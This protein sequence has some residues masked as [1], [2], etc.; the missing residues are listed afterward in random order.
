MH[1]FEV[2]KETDPQQ[3][4]MSIMMPSQLPQRHQQQRQPSP[5]AVIPPSPALPP[6]SSNPQFQLNSEKF[7]RNH[8]GEDNGQFAESDNGFKFSPSLGVAESVHSVPSSILSKKRK[9]TKPFQ[10]VEPEQPPSRAPL[11]KEISPEE[12]ERR[13]ALVRESKHLFFSRFKDDLLKRELSMAEVNTSATTRKKKPLSGAKTAKNEIASLRNLQTQTELETNALRQHGDALRD[14]VQ[15]SL[16]IPSSGNSPP[17]PRHPRRGRPSSGPPVPP[18]DATL[19]RES[20]PPASSSNRRPKTS[21]SSSGAVR[22]QHHQQ[23]QQQQALFSQQQQQA[24]VRDIYAGVD[25]LGIGVDVENVASPEGGNSIVVAAIT[26]QSVAEEVGFLVGDI[27]TAL[28]QRPI[29]S[30]EEFLEFEKRMLDDSDDSTVTIRVVRPYPHSE[31]VQAVHIIVKIAD[32]KAQH[33]QSGAVA[34]REDSNNNNNASASEPPSWE[35]QQQQQQQTEPGDGPSSPNSFSSS[36][37]GDRQ[38]QQ[39]SSNFSSNTPAFSLPSQEPFS[40]DMSAPPFPLSSRSASE[41]SIRLPS[42]KIPSVPSSVNPFED[43]SGRPFD[44]AARQGRA[45]Y[46]PAAWATNNRAPTDPSTIPPIPPL[47]QS[48]GG[49]PSSFPPSRTGSFSSFPPPPP[50][51]EK[52]FSSTAPTSTVA[53]PRGSGP[54]NSEGDFPFLQPFPMGT[55]LQPGFG[56]KPYGFEARGNSQGQPVMSPLPSPPTN[57]GN[58]NLRGNDGMPPSEFPPP[59]RDFRGPPFGRPEFQPPPSNQFAS[60]PPPPSQGEESSGFLTQ[61]EPMMMVPPDM[62]GRPMMPFDMGMNEGPMGGGME[63]RGPGGARL[64]PGVPPMPAHLMNTPPMGMPDMF[65]WD[66]PKPRGWKQEW[67]WPPPMNPEFDPQTNMPIRPTDWVGPW[68]PDPPPP[69]GWRDEW[70]WPPPIF[71]DWNPSM[72]PPGRPKDWVGPW[73]P[74]PPGMMMMEMGPPDMFPPDMGPPLDFEWMKD[75]N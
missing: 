29:H 22:Q 37:T 50:T 43:L 18:S 31:D 66:P 41:P 2:S 58:T 42:S 26:P 8:S 30:A 48:G 44:V 54:S 25:R 13:K 73:P 56:G 6:T 71:P 21:L 52:M 40:S 28:N 16:G 63:N 46:T 70:S 27:I 65:T 23:Q 68:P 62:A 1:A 74:I 51:Q 57:N 35:Q 39:R 53:P 4:A 69:P 49:G 36:S 33:A 47:F 17:R 7:Q 64:P 60:Y 61:R 38:S 20:L 15:Q 11:I 34:S 55:D 10:Q 72:P 45:V 19:Q 75:S 24:V 9:P 5:P 3:L 67:S 32:V 14:L 12:K 59:S